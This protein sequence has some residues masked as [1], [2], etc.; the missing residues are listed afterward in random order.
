MSRK[1]NLLG[2]P[3]FT[4]RTD[5]IWQEEKRHIKCLQD[6]PGMALYA[7]TGSI[8]KGGIELPVYRCA[9]G[10]T[11]LESFHLYLARFIPGTVASALNFQAFFL[12]GLYRWNEDRAAAALQ[13]PQ[14]GDQ[15]RSFNTRLKMQVT[16][17]CT[18][19]SLHKTC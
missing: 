5:I 1:S 16:L 11:C 2:E 19:F 7:K 14:A 10:S 18:L 6:P 4:E 13:G 8:R 15:F 12:N 17:S 3:L 9:R